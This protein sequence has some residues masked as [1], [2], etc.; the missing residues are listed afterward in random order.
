MRFRA[1]TIIQTLVAMLVFL[2]ALM[3]TF[4][5]FSR[6]SISGDDP[7]AIAAAEEHVRN[8]V[9][10]FKS[11][12]SRID[13]KPG[14]DFTRTM[15]YEW[16]TIT[17]TAAMYQGYSDLMQLTVSAKIPSIHKEIWRTALVEIAQDESFEVW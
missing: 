9:C 5:L 8:I 14:R 12:K 11:G 16:G 15:E 13:S 6:F 17:L 2:T 7:Y 3:L 1:E 4:G 10:D